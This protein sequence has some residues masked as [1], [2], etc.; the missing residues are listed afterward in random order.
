MQAGR[1]VIYTDVPEITYENVIDVL[2]RAMVDH[3]ANSRRIDYLIDYE[4]GNQPL[5]R[6]KKTRTDINA[7]CVDNIA[8]EATEFWCG[9]AFGN[10][11]TL[12]QNGNRD[13]ADIPEGIKLLN[14]NYDLAKVKTK[15]QETARYI[16][17]DGVANVFIDVNTEW[18]DGKSY[19]TYD[20]LDP[21]TSF[22]VRSG[23]YTDHRPMLGV[24]YRHDSIT[25]RNYF[26]CFTKHNR[27]EII[28]L[29]EITNGNWVDETSNW[30]HRDR[31]GE[32]N[33][34]GKIP[35]VEYI[36]SHDRMGLWE[37]QIDEMDNLN[38]LISDFTND[39]DQ[40]TQAIWHGND[41]DFPK[42]VIKSEDGTETEVL[43]KPG[44]NE[45][46]LTYTTS[47]GKQPF[48][49]PLA[50]AYDY[51]GMLNNIQYRRQTILQKCNVPQRNDSSGGSTGVA[52][53]DATGWSQAETTASKMQMIIDSCKMEEVEV[54]LAAIKV[55]PYVEQDSPL[56][57][58]TL[59]DIEPSIKRQ[60]TY[61]MTTK[62][63]SIATLLSHGFA[64]EDTL[65]AIPIFNDNNEVCARSGELV[66]KYQ[67]N[68]FSD[69]SNSFNDTER[70]P[71][72]DRIMGDLSD[73]IDQSPMIDKSRVD[74]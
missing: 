44:T 18:E 52:M 57:K 51:T 55:S 33:P 35:I 32:V 27:Y 36:R 46:V 68:L 3:L 31:S 28:D 45:W 21:R 40:N 53:S 22:I 39:V 48:I 41:V 34:L 30:H 56:R 24:T 38:L 26:T 4:N 15:T 62:V 43:K 17:I 61:E 2:R 1:K 19:F 71:D 70:E 11:I 6:E 72:S 9:F 69:T 50:V 10:P 73:N 47:D 23:Y 20:V 14:Q 29:H 8:N 5:V 49:N 59:A 58:L 42:E 74:K 64:L 37:R 25:G 67:E 13:D 63:N 54:V 66:K 60:K 7:H 65:E 12:V 16:I